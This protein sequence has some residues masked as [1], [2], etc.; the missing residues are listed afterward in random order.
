[1]DGTTSPKPT[2]GSS[3]VG[4]WAGTGLYCDQCV[5]RDGHAQRFA[6]TWQRKLLGCER[7]PARQPVAS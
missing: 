7:Q 6:L 5:H 1:L 2:C 4:R 3:T